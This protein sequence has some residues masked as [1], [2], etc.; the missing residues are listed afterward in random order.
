MLFYQG[1]AALM[2][3]GG[4]NLVFNMYALWVGIGLLICS[5]GDVFMDLQVQ[6]FPRMHS[7]L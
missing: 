5:A 6:L 4:K 3:R 1:F 7:L 2:S